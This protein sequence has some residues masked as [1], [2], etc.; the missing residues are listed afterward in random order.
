MNKKANLKR[1]SFIFALDSEII[2]YFSLFTYGKT[3]RLKSKRE[4]NKTAITKLGN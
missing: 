2:E 3:K 4:N 1:I